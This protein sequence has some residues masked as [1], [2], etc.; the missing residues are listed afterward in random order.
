MPAAPVSPDG[1]LSPRRIAKVAEVVAREIIHDIRGLAPGTRLPPE[2]E[3]LSRYRVGRGS[4]REALR[5]LEVQGLI[6]IRPGSGGG[7]V[8]ARVQPR[9]YAEM[10]SLYCHAM[11]ASYRDIMEARFAMEP[12]MA[13]LAAIRQDA[14]MI[15]K[16]KA[17]AANPPTNVHEYLDTELDFHTLLSTMSGN[18]VLDLMGRALK[19]IYTDK[20]YSVVTPDMRAHLAEDHMAIVEAIE[21]GD[22]A[23]AE[24]AMRAHMDQFVRDAAQRMPGVL[25]DIVD[26]H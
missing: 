19:I 18:P 6:V 4:L 26:W 15:E 14:E 12:V 1:D 16:L 25:D 20:V 23:A 21:Q 3:M 24:E 10:T 2:S 9:N 17:V 5:I 13:R 7:P 11:G 22:A 8:V